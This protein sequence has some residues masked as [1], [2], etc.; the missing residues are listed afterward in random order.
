MLALITC[1]IVIGLALLGMWWLSGYDAHLT[2]EDKVRDFVRRAL[3]CG[4]T[5]L[6]AG[7]FLL[8][9]G[10]IQAMPLLLLLGGLLVLIW[11]GPLTE[12]LARWFH[13]LIYHEDKR[14]FDPNQT[15]RDLDRVA[16]LIKSGRKEEAIQLCQALKES[17]DVSVLALDTLLEHLGVKPEPAPTTRP[18]IEARRLRLEKRFPE[19]EAILNSLLLQNAANVDAAM[20]LMRLY[21]EDL[22]R[23]DQ[24]EA[25]LESLARQ[26]HVPSACSF[27]PDRICA[28]FHSGMERGKTRAGSR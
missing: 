15:V 25:V 11:C 14:E 20:M 26:P 22:H 2:G 18:L 6:L 24:A 13:Q 9:P 23:P 4:L 16:G 12:M 3:R 21:A 8:L 5:V 27:R 1:V 28:P 19:A 10:A 7:V 17:G